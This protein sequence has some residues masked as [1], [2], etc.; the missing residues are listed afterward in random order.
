MKAA[1]KASMWLSHAM[2]S[3]LACV[4]AFLWAPSH[5]RGSEGAEKGPPPIGEARSPQRLGMSQWEKN[6]KAPEG[7]LTLEACDPLRYIFSGALT[8]RRLSARASTMRLASASARR[9]SRSCDS[10]PMMW[11]LV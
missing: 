6:N 11:Q 9:A 7:A 3:A 1:I 2:R 4:A 10:S 8:P 5:G